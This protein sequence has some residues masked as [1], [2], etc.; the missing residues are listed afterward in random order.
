[1]KVL[2]VLLYGMGNISFGII[3]RLFGVS[4]VAVYKWIGGEA[5]RL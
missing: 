1:M 4:G 2:A 5:S 3:G